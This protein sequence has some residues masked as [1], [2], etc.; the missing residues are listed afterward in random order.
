LKK[1]FVSIG[2]IFGELEIRD[3]QIFLLEVGWDCEK[4]I[5]AENILQIE[6]IKNSII[7]DSDCGQVAT[8]RFLPIYDN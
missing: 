1:E 2:I 5:L 6:Y 4:K 3:D 7:D 8:G